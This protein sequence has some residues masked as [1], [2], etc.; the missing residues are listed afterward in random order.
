MDD[1]PR[2]A[3]DPL[4]KVGR[5]LS[6]QSDLKLL[7]ISTALLVLFIAVTLPLLGKVGRKV[8][9]ELAVAQ[10]KPKTAPRDNG[11]KQR[12]K[13]LTGAAYRT[14]FNLGLSKTNFI[15]YKETPIKVGDR[16]IDDIFWELW[17]ANDFDFES[18]VAEFSKG[19]TGI[20]RGAALDS[21]KYDAKTFEITLT[22]DGHQ[23]HRVIFSKT[24]VEAEKDAAALAM[25]DV[26]K[27]VP[28]QPYNGPPRVAIIIDDI[29]FRDE[30]EQGFLA[31]PGRLTFAVLPFS[32]S[33]VAFAKKAHSL[34][35]EIMLHLPMEPKAYPS[36]RPGKGGLLLKMG[37]EE[38]RQTLLAN[39]TQVPYI[40]GVNNHMGSAF[41]SDAA[42]MDLVI[43]ELKGR[44]LYFVDSR[45]AGSA[46]G[47]EVARQLGVPAAARNV[48]LDHTPTEDVIA[49]QFDL[50]MRTAQRQGYAIAI[51]HPHKATLDTLRRKL[52]E[53]AARNIALVPPSELVH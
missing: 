22:L 23:T 20:V 1:K 40:S 16:K 53:L 49:K 39:L 8:T 34:G 43:R 33:G 21:K 6:A 2:R 29:G 48:F 3:K 30:I 41:T 32:K 37:N 38:I 50:L 25:V 35:R 7:L 11:F 31:L 13:E 36:I 47:Y 4:A 44:N 9:G 27:V 18:A 51:G 26:D 52:P 28:K 42:K 17:V 46:K 45:T 5:V 24:G 10:P 15:S 14:F 12:Y 19:A